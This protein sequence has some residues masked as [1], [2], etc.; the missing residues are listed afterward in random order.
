VQVT[1]GGRQAWF[2]IDTGAPDIMVAP[3]LAKELGLALQ[4]AGQGVFAGGVRAAVQ[5]TIV[6]ELQI[7]GLKIVNVPAGV[8]AG[9]LPIPGYKI[10]GIVGTGLLMHFLSTL[11]YCQGRLVLHPRSSSAGFEQAAAKA[12]ANIV[13]MWLVSDHFIMARG[14][15]QHAA[16]GTFVIDTGLAGGGV[17][18]TKAALDEAGVVVD[19]SKG[20]AGVGGGGPVTYYPFTV[21][22]TLGSLTVDNVPGIYIPGADP[23]GGLPFKTAGTLSHGFFRHS[24]LTFDFDAMKLV[25]EAC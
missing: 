16:E 10:E 17:T 4:D 13:P 12:G 24:R 15:L 20:Q 1:I 22:A 7:G 9:G 18:A 25:T 19:M 14:H 23:F 2:L 8:R 5:R 3:E 6:P 21:G 11:D